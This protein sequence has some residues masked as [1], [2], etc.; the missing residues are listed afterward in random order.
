MKGRR[1]LAR[2]LVIAAAVVVLGPWALVVLLA[3][4][5]PL[6]PELASARAMSTSVVLRDR[7]GVALR[8][9]AADDGDKAR[10]LSLAEMGDRLPRAVVAA[11]DRRFFRHP[12]VDPLALAR[13]AAQLVTRGRIV[14]GGSTLTMQLARTVS[15]HARRSVVGKVREMALALR[16]EASL[17]KGRIL[18]EYLNRVELAPG[19]R[20]AEAASRYLFD[21]RPEELSLAEAALLAGLPRGPAFYDPRR[22]TARA[23]ARRDR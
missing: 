13:A 1:A 9:L 2:R 7:D 19:L 11:E 14:S 20:G 16:I 3:A 6:P 5:T 8:E 21:K 10:W 4:A 18:E 17:S 23:V 12:G 22:G 15:P